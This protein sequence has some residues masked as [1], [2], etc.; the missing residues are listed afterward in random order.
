MLDLPI[1]CM[2]MDKRGVKDRNQTF[3]IKKKNDLFEN[4]F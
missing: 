4:N 2:E 1:S 3:L